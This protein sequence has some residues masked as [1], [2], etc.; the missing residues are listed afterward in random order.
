[1]ETLETYLQ[2]WDTA[3]DNKSCRIPLFDLSKPPQL[4]LA[5][6]QLFVKS[7]Y[8]ARGHFYRFLWYVGSFANTADEKKVV[9]DNIVEEFGGARRSHE[10]LY[11]DF[12]QSLDVD[13]V[14]E[15]QS[16]AAYLPFLKVF[17]QGHIDWLLTK[18]WNHKWAAFSA[19]ERLDNIDYENL[20]KLVSSLGLDE[21]ALRFFD[22]HRWVKHYEGASN[23]LLKIWELHP[24]SVKSSF[25]FIGAHQLQMW[26]NLSNL[27]LTGAG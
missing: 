27:V 1:M 23:S 3:Y 5:Q 14:S 6:K 4:S 17:N 22:A 26:R 13:L 9:V 18:D 16:E 24:Q 7:F 8:H 19:Y 15:I 12:A 25:E 2:T 20:Y 11:F 21:K 10:Q